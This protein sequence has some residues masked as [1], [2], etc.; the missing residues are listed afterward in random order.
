MPDTRAA[1]AMRAGPARGFSLLEMLVAIAVLGLALGALYQGVSG[2]TRNLRTDERY[3]YAVE[4]ARSVLADNAVVAPG[5]ADRA[6][7]TS[8]GFRWEFR[9]APLQGAQGGSVAERLRQ[10]RVTVAWQDG[11]RQRQVQLHSVVGVSA[12]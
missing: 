6:G 9:S 7:E 11:V 5:G 2:A 10:V 8:G 1:P 12:R 4:L 3:A